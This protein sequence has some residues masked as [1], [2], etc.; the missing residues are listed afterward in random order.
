MLISQKRPLMRNSRDK[1]GDTLDALIA[2]S[3]EAAIGEKMMA[4]RRNQAPPP[5]DEPLRALDEAILEIMGDNRERTAGDVDLALSRKGWDVP[6]EE[7]K[8]RMTSLATKG[9]LK[10]ST[11]KQEKYDHYCI[12]RLA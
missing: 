5:M 8:S 12:W 1:S 4:V 2:R 7:R 11:G 9:Y 3:G 10:S 6:P